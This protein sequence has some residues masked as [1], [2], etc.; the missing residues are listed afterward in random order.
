MNYLNRNF[1]LT[2]CFPSSSR[3]P[4]KL[5]SYCLIFK[6][7]RSTSSRFPCKLLSQF[8]LFSAYLLRSSPFARRRF[9]GLQE[10]IIHDWFRF[11]KRFFEVF[12]EAARLVSL[13]LFP[14]GSLAFRVSR[15]P[16]QLI[17]NTMPILQ[18][19]HLFSSFLNF[20]FRL[21][22]AYFFSNYLM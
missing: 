11:V 1:I 20:F 22:S 12:F 17:Y 13:L 16:E 18:S 14:P 7:L 9:G 4:F 5:R 8:V 10:L 3:V 6:V 15:S 2:S 21:I 19:Q